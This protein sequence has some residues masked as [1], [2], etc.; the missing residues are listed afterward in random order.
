MSPFDYL[1][2][3]VSIVIGLAIANVLT[4]L[5]VVITARERVDFYWPPLA[6]A[7]WLF[8]IAV[9]HW[10]AQWS[11]HNT[12]EWTFPTF[13]LE[14]FVPVLLFLLSSLVLPEREENG[15]LDL[16]EWY[17]RNRAWF[18]AVL[19]LVPATSL[20][21]E[22]TRTGRIGSPVNLGFLLFFEVMIAA[23]FV[24]KSRRAQ[25][26]ITGQAMVA[27]LIYV[28]VLFLRLPG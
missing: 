1:T 28:V 13:C 19:F 14:V 27:T 11:V 2:V 3:L 22:F 5:S 9:Q 4:R 7:I 26:W 23:A 12:R 20:A 8:F 17:F 18:F 6:W 15:K 10:W 24:A 25:E 21:E 16:G